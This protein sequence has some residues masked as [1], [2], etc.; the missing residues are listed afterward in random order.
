MYGLVMIVRDAAAT[1][2]ACLASLRPIIGHWMICDTGSVDGTPELIERLLDGIPGTLYR[3]EWLNFGHNRSLAF[4][5]ARGT[6]DWLIASDADMTWDLGA[7]VPSPDVEAYTVDM[8]GEGFANR[9]P[10]ILRGDLPWRSVGAVHEYTTLGRP[11][12]QA[13]S[14]VRITQ[15]GTHAW[16]P[17][18]GLWHLGMLE[19]EDS[20]DPD[21]ART[22]FYLAKTCEDL[23]FTSRAKGYYR[24]RIELGGWPEE[25]YYAAWRA[26]ALVAD[27][28]VRLDALLRAWELRPTRLE[29]LYDLADGLNQHGQHRAAWHLTSITVEPC[30]DSLFVHRWVWDYGILFQRQIAAWWVEAPEFG[31]ITDRLRSLDLPENIR[32]AVE[33]NAGLRAA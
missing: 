11:A 1:I 2:E 9:L 31:L 15:P 20:R 4:G 18:K 5:R 13:S 16:T 28:P 19:T 23:G 6:A 29:A 8:G 27:W 30:F 22:T 3:D 21:N 32:S 10:L 7:F 17:E 33:R 14:E 12:I 24:R 26:A 25:T